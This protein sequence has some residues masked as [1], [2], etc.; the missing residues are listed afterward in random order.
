MSVKFLTVEEVAK[1]LRVS[2]ATVYALIAS[3][4][5]KA[6]QVGRQYRISEDDLN[7]YIN[8]GKRP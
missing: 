5:L 8:R 6:T 7:E 1:I 2:T 4:E 3:G